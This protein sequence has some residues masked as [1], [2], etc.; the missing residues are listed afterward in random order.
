MYRYTVLGYYEGIIRRTIAVATFVLA[1]QAT[2]IQG[3]Q[4]YHMTIENGSTP[5]I[6]FFAIASHGY[7]L[8]IKKR[9]HPDPNVGSNLDPKNPP[10][11][12]GCRP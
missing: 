5:N 9:I 4:G 6:S 2:W 8:W 3:I 12:S 7:V 1:I 10:E 11:F